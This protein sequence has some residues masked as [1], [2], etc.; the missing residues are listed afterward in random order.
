MT[1]VKST[2]KRIVVEVLGW[3]LVVVGIAALVAARA[4]AAERSS[5]GCLL[6]T[7][8]EWAERRLEPV[9]KAALRGAADSVKTWP[10]ILLSV[11]GVLWL[12]GLGILWIV[13]PAAPA[14]WP[15]DDSWWLAG[16]W[17]TG[18]TLVV[19]GLV[20]GAMLVYSYLNFR[21]I[22][23]EQHAE[24]PRLSRSL[25]PMGLMKCMP[26]WL[27]RGRWDARVP[28]IWCCSWPCRR[29][30]YWFSSWA[31]AP[32]GRRR[33]PRPRPA[34]AGC[35]GLERRARETRASRRAV[36]LDQPES[37]EPMPLVTQSTHLV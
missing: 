4:R 20:A 5:R 18:V 33:A 10:R 14:W 3:I 19:S 2:A 9:K 24:R 8:Y 17:A 23:D 32:A 37:T 15:L 35:R 16:G 31:A 26:T 13:R 1:R 25:F 36:A 27:L 21:E 29:R 6:A 12:I 34:T 28:R 11:F 22:K 30:A 7:Q